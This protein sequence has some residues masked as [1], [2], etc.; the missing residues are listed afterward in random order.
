MLHFVELS[1]GLNR[2]SR[3]E[4][5]SDTAS[6]K[7]DNPFSLEENVKEISL[8]GLWGTLQRWMACH[9]MPLQGC[10]CT[11][12]CCC[13]ICLMRFDL[14]E[15]PFKQVSL[16]RGICES[17]VIRFFSFHVQQLEGTDGHFQQYQQTSCPHGAYQQLL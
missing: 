1:R 4:A 13:P 7:G 15:C 16:M 12:A 5:L 10:T 9:H 8:N 14:S 2:L 3:A 11:A 6:Y 17:D